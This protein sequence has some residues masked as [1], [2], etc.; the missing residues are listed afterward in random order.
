MTFLISQIKAI[1]Y[2]GLCAFAVIQYISKLNLNDEEKSIHAVDGDIRTIDAG[3]RAKR[4]AP[5]LSAGRSALRVVR[6]G[7]GGAGLPSSRHRVLG[8]AAGKH[9]RGRG[10]TGGGNHQ[11]TAGA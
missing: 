11:E 3:D 8:R 2:L 1:F 9:Q 4:T 10:D 6:P 7:R 5:T